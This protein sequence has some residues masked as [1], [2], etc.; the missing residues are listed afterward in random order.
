MTLEVDRRLHHIGWP[1]HPPHAP[2]SHR[3]GLGDA[4]DDHATVGNL[5]HERG[6]RVEF[7]TAVGEVLINFIGHDPNII[8][9]GPLADGDGLFA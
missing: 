9:G 4:V 3:I 5:G 6:H 2:A 7:M 8:F 1:D